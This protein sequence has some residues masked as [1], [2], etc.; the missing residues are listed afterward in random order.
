MQGDESAISQ[1]TPSI[2]IALQQCRMRWVRECECD[3][4]ECECSSVSF[5]LLFLFFPPSYFCSFIFGVG[6][7]IARIAS[8]V[9]PPGGAE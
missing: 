9:M 8:P 1:H 5:L 2:V 6:A 4:C 3:V 7:Y